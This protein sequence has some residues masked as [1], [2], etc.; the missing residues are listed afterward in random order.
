MDW[1]DIAGAVARNAPMLG[2]LLAGPPGAAVG[3][4]GS[5]IASA[6]GVGGTPDEVAQA[7]TTNPDAAVKLKQ[8]EADRQV[9]LQKLVSAQAIADI[10][11]QQQAT[12]D[13]NK[14]MQAEAAAEHWPTYSWRPA[15]GFAVA[16]AL[17]LAVLVVAV[18][19]GG[20][21]FAGVK[22]DVLQYVPPMLAALAGLVAVASPILGIASYFRGRMQADPNVPTVNRG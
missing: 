19:Y 1:K 4:V 17:V 7:L 20:V 21:M 14:T 2:G 11:A 18:A 16:I 13:V 15:I 10:Q 3:A 5:M 22:P 12:S 9:D 6:L 8:I